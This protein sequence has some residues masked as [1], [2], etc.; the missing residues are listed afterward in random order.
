MS[1]MEIIVELKEKVGAS[2][3]SVQRTVSF[4]EFLFSTK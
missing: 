3:L 4:E 2:L 1:A